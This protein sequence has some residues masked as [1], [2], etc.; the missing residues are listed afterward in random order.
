M[1]Y[2][3]CRCTYVYICSIHP[4]A[5]F[6][7]AIGKCIMFSWSSSLCPNTFHNHLVAYS[8]I[9]IPS[10]I[11]KTYPISTHGLREKLVTRH[12][13]LGRSHSL[14]SKAKLWCDH[15][16]KRDGEAP[17]GI[18]QATQD[19]DQGCDGASEKLER[20][21]SMY[22][23]SLRNSSKR[24]PISSNASFNTYPRKWRASLLGSIESSRM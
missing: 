18:V 20:C 22:I 1:V 21:R 24:S 11:T 23:A 13:S 3:F 2:T 15:K 17:Q 9:L 16:P 6:S 19:E 4:R 10:W 14:D 7:Q 12:L 8:C 5:H